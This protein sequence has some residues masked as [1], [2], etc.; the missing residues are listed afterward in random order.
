MTIGKNSIPLYHLELVRDRNLPYRKLSKVEDAVQ[1]FHD[2]L[3]RSPIEQVAVIYVDSSSHIV[4]AEIVAMGQLTKVSISMRE[5]FRGAI[6]ASVPAIILGHNHPSGDP[7]PSAQDIA[8]TQAASYSAR[9]L[10]IQLWDHIIVSPDGRH[11]SMYEF[12]KL[13]GGSTEKNIFEST[14]NV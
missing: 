12:S 5:I 1:I 8:I 3:D 9:L 7:S 10:E 13:P 14:D 4:G 6:V 2:L 11:T